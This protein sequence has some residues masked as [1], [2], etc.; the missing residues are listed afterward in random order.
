[1]KHSINNSEFIRI[2]EELEDTIKTVSRMYSIPI[3]E[4]NV[5]MNNIDLCCKANIWNSGNI[6]RCSRN[7]INEHYCSIH[8][9][10]INKYGKLKL[11]NYNNVDIQ[12]NNVDAKFDKSNYNEI[13][14]D[15]VEYIPG[16]REAESNIV[17]HRWIG[18][19]K[20]VEV[21]IQAVCL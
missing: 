2:N 20:I 12:H 11:G 14:G 18:F 21:K 15:L 19:V 5:I 16:W 1:M 7:K 17:Y 9:N 4:L 8:L 3:D 13:D 10:Q 6:I